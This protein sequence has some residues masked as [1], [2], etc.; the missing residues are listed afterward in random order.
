ALFAISGL[1][2]GFIT[3]AALDG[4]DI[5]GRASTPT[6]RPTATAVE[7]P[8]P[9]PT[10]TMSPLLGPSHF[11]FRATAAPR[12]VS[13][14]QTFT[15]SAALVAADG[16]TPVANVTCYLRAP[17]GS[18]PL[19]TPWP[20]PI[21]SDATGQVI[22]RLTAPSVAPGIYAIEVYALGERGWSFHFDPS[23]TILEAPAALA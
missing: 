15:I 17:N 9:S 14:G 5:V 16:I 3:R 23:V 21:V 20:E 7:S 2:A 13:P 6:G 4:L 8:T 11:T 1:G 22:W 12:T 18:P 19:Y 10:P